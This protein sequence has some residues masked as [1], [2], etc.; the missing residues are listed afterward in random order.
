MTL[1]KYCMHCSKSAALKKVYPHG[2]ILKEERMEIKTC[3]DPE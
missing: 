3:M 2:P 1:T